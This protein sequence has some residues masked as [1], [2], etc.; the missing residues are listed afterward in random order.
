MPFTNFDSRHFTTAEQTAL[1]DALN[2]LET[3]VA[4]KLANLSADE[5]R[6]YGSV[7][8]QNK[9]IINK[10]KDY[11]IGEPILSSQDVDWDEFEQD[12]A[13]P[14]ILQ[15]AVQRLQSIITGLNAAKILHDWDNYQ[16]A[17]TDYEFAKY[18]NNSGAIGYAT[19]VAELGQFFTG[20]GSPTPTPPIGDTGA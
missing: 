5:R 15:N 8:E 3:T 10:V 4:G 13:T 11:R 18:K 2:T 1:T 20:G 7:N 12:Y 19:K 9:L 14:S 6:Q 17:L 16:A